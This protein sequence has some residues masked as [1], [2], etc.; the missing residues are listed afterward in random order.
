MTEKNHFFSQKITDKNQRR[1]CTKGRIHHPANV[2]PSGVKIVIMVVIWFCNCGLLRHIHPKK[3]QCE[4]SRS[5]LK[6]NFARKIGKKTKFRRIDFRLFLH[7][8]FKL[9]CKARRKI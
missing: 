3:K 7:K 9:H 4:T 1:F 2:S 6:S 5:G 8:A